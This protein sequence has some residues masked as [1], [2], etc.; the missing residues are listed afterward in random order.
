MP[1]P[2]RAIDELLGSADGVPLLRSLLDGAA[3]ADGLTAGAEA[4]SAGSADAG[5]P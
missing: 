3:A 4:R 1:H 5:A 2:E